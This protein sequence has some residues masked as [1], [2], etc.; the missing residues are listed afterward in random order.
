MK[1]SGED[2][3]EAI[4]FLSMDGDVQSADI[5]RRLGVTRPSVH[6]AISILKE[7]GCIEQ[8]PYG[9]VTLTGEGRALAESVQR[10]HELVRSFLREVLGVSPETAEQDACR[11]EHALSEET[12]QCWNIFM[13]RWKEGNVSAGKTVRFTKED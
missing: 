12:M 4:L 10:K 5:A 13:T 7:R 2:Y 11:M 8:E 1:A 9:R 6:R 3:L